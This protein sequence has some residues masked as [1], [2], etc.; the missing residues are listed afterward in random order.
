MKNRP[1]KWQDL[2]YSIREHIIDN[3][4]LSYDAYESSREEAIA[5]L[6]NG[7]YHRNG[8][9][10]Q[11]HYSKMSDNI[12]FAIVCD[13]VQRLQEQLSNLIEFRN[14]LKE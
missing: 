9:L 14:K 1:A 11:R 7:D 13:N 8:D 10:V 3:C 4:S 5:A 12:L 2:P 6:L